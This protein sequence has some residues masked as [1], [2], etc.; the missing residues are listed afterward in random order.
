MLM[1]V[2]VIVMIEDKPKVKLLFSHLPSLS[3]LLFSLFSYKLSLFLEAKKKW[4][5]IIDDA[6][7]QSQ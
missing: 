5:G 6:S 1:Y 7:V 2:I 3:S 4:G